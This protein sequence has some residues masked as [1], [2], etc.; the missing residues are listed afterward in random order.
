MAAT[1]P[2]EFTRMLQSPVPS[3]P[4][5]FRQAPPPEPPRAHS[6]D[7]GEFTRMLESPM[8]PRGLAGQPL[9]APRPEPIPGAAAD[10]PAKE[11]PSEFTRMFKAPPPAAPEA[12]PKPVKRAVRRPPVRHKKSKTGMWIAVGALVLVVLIALAWFLFFR[13]KAA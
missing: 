8:S 11:G 4:Q 3:G 10:A 12:Q 9:A 2:G 13:G 7:P 5:P 1:P 6:H